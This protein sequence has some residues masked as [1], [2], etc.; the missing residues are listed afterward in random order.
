MQIV[1]EVNAP[2]L[3][4]KETFIVLDDECWRLD[5]FNLFPQHPIYFLFMTFSAF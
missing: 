5:T 3:I 2:L 1:Y 4:I